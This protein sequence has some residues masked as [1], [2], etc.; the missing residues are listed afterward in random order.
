[1]DPSKR[2]TNCIRCHPFASVHDGSVR[3][4]KAG[5]I[6][7]FKKGMVRDGPDCPGSGHSFVSCSVERSFLS[8]LHDEYSSASFNGTLTTKY[9]IWF[10]NPFLEAC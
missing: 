10:P 2:R 7:Y 4:V 6:S 9:R 1:M 5:K 3:P 8:G